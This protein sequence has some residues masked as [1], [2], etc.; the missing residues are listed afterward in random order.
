MKLRQYQLTAQQSTL[1][2][3]KAGERTQLGVM[4]TGCGKTIVFASLIRAKFPKR[5]MVLAHRHELIWQARDKIQR[6][7]GFKVDVEMGEYKASVDRD[8][9][10]PKSQVIVSTIQTHCAGGDGGGRMGKF[11]PKD[12]GV[13]IVDEAHHATSRSYRR[14][15]DYYM[16]NPDLVVL[17]VTATPDRSDEEALGQVFGSVA[18][19]YEILDAIHDGWLTPIDQ[20]MVSVESLDFG[21]VRT[22]AG[23]LNQADLDAVMT[24]E[25]PLHGVAS[26]T[27][28]IIG[29]RR[30][31]GFAA[32]VHHAQMLSEIFNRHRPGM[33]A[34]VCAGTDKD[35]R[36]KI[37]SDFARGDIQWLWNCGV[38]T[39][40]F[41]D[42]GVAVIAMARPT[43]SRSLY[44]QMAGRGMRPLESI[45]PRLNNSLA[46]PLRRATI[47]SSSKPACLII[48]FVGNSGKHK[49]MSTADILGGNASDEAI[50]ATKLFARKQGMP[51]RIAEQLEDEEER[52]EEMKKKR[53]EAE[54]R[55]ANLTAKATYKTQSIDPFDILQ[56]KPA[57][58]RGWHEGKALSEGQSNVLRKAGLDPAKY[59]YAQGSQLCHAIIERWHDDRCTLK[60]AGL[61]ERC[62][63]SKQ[64]ATEMKF[65]D[66]SVA[67]D[68]AAKNN[69]HKPADWKPAPKV[70]LADNNDNVPF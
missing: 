7:T 63:W 11:D 62:G 48:D 54:R 43:K 31:I 53:L 8:L 29:D 17:G 1:D 32:S 23:D 3:W 44:A 38:F 33:S 26:S 51:V 28:D 34:F 36:K 50:E 67:I 15:I 19:D 18:F 37:V 20:Q 21:K 40:G 52:I 6:V 49:L 65:K 41:D 57:K 68:R 30:G 60:Q 70:V 64:E 46:A 4:P 47:A 14:V 10:H 16:Q 12:F 55:K 69:W 58:V 59:D 24:A 39:E 66:A 35:E 45:V 61:L 42:S 25:K 27:I 5:A 22:T 56:I 13:L 9:F 2:G